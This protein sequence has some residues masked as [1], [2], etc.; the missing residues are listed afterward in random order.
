MLV[1][2]GNPDRRRNFVLFSLDSSERKM[3]T[4]VLLERWSSNLALR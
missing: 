4:I 2:V 3:A 1:K